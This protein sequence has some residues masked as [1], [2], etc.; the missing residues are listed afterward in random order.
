MKL[1]W[2]LSTLVTLTLVMLTGCN[3]PSSTPHPAVQ[4]AQARDATQAA[5][6]SPQQQAASSGGNAQTQPQNSTGNIIIS[7]VQLSTS[8]YYFDY[9]END[10]G[11]MDVTVSVKVTS[12]ANVN[13]VGVQRLFISSP[14]RGGG[15]A[16]EMSPV[17]NDRFAYTIRSDELTY[18]D[19]R[20]Y[21]LDLVFYASDTAGNEVATGAWGDGVGD[22]HLWPLNPVNVQIPKLNLLPCY[23]QVS[24]TQAP[25]V[26][27]YP[28]F[29]ST[30]YLAL[31]TNP[32]TSTAVPYTVVSGYAELRHQ[33]TIDLD[34]DGSGDEMA[35]LA[36]SPENPIRGHA[37]GQYVGSGSGVAF[38]PVSSVPTY[39]TCKS[40]MSWNP[41][42]MINVGNIFCYKTWQNTYGY[43]IIDKIEQT[44]DT[45]IPVWVMGFS[46]TA[47]IE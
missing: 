41:G 18:P 21:S 29:T 30:P 11:P 16:D 34:F 17:G 4:T 20:A 23:A 15:I 27:G 33:E 45:E 39:E 5:Y 14:P 44:G 22:G 7:D 6:Q 8:T 13:H 32:S 35:Y 40:V 28:T 36:D 24:E 1:K 47:W 10:C 9:G 19:D 43:L 38:A 12:S 46:Y 2:T 26:N 31:P 3:M 37:I 25:Q 42:I